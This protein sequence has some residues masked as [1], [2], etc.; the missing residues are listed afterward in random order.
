[1]RAQTIFVVSREKIW[2]QYNEFTYPP[3][4]PPVLD[5]GSVVDSLLNVLHIHWFVGALYLL[6]LALIFT[7]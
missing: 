6:I 4:P 7:N 2:C 1:M 5:S 3:P